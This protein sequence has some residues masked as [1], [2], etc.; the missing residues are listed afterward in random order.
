VHIQHRQG[1][2]SRL[3]EDQ[4]SFGNQYQREDTSFP[5][6]LHPY[7]LLPQS[8][9]FSSGDA[10][11]SVLRH[12]RDAERPSADDLLQKNA[13]QITASADQSADSKKHAAS[14]DPRR[15]ADLPDPVSP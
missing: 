9:R 12:R 13:S 3:G 8:Y 2:F 7:P 11:L 15:R 4:N 10:G 14:S 6:T 1:T 5:Y